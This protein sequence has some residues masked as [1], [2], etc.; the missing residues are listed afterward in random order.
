MSGARRIVARDSGSRHNGNRW[1]IAYFRHE[2]ESAGG[3]RDV[4]RRQRPALRG[5]TRARAPRAVAG[6]ITYP[7][8]RRD[9]ALLYG[10]DQCK[11]EELDRPHTGLLGHQ[12]GRRFQE[13]APRCQRA[14][15]KLRDDVDKLLWLLDLRH[16]A[17][18]FHD[19]QARGADVLMIE[20]STVHGY[21]GILTPPD[22]QR[23]HAQ[24]S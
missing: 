22:D 18:L 8:A 24:A 2:R 10:R 1:E 21:H 15:Q 9:F 7:L 20:L 5:R 12:D 14:S 19:H 4:P 13:A 11:A 16:V 3:R 23:R 6:S 17:T